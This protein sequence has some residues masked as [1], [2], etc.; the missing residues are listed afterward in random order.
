MAEFFGIDVSEHNGNIDWNKVKAAGVKFAMIR[1]GYGQNNID[2]KFVHNISEC[3]RLGI[4]CGV[5][6]FSYALSTD[7]AKRE[8]QYCLAAVKP[9][10]LEYPIAFDFEYDS[11]SYA[12]KRGVTITK[13]IASEIAKAFC[14]EIEKANYYVL[15]YANQDYLTRYFDSSVAE[16]FGVWLAAWNNAAKPARTCQ[17]WQ[18]SSA[19]KIDGIFGNVDVNKS[20]VDFPTVIKNAGLN[21]LKNEAKQMN[22][23]ELAEQW[24]IENK[25]IQGYGGNNYGWGDSMTREQMALILYRFYNKLKSGE[26]K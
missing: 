22:E 19:G 13:A 10:K 2:K 16:K 8:A 25:L 20:F 5:Y 26:L 11:V 7:A 3:N 18:Y 14:R 9:Y 24:A 12:Q 17:I 6:W 23:N 15:N 1:A 21:G 4:P